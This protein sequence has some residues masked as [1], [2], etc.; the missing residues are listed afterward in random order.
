M[1][2]FPDDYQGKVSHVGLKNLPFNSTMEILNY[3]FFSFPF[4]IN[5]LA[6]MVAG[7]VM[8][9]AFALF[10]AMCCAPFIWVALLL[11]LDKYSFFNEEISDY[12]A[13]K[14]P[15]SIKD[16]PV[17][18]ESMQLRRRLLVLLQGDLDTAKRLLSLERRNSPGKAE[19]WYLRKVIWDL[20]R[21]RY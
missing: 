8:I 18:S 9:A 16:L 3:L 7:V 13:T 14:Q 2:T 4:P 17:E 11:G 19:V 6:L 10:I 15:T 5:Y 21:D 1:R 20:E 12:Q